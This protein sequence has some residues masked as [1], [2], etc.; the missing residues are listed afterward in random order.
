MTSNEIAI[1]LI[2]IAFFIQD[3]NVK[4]LEKRINQL[5]KE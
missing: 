2:C 3:L 1:T 5:E 4:R